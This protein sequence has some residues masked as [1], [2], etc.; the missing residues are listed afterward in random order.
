M[1]T[2]PIIRKEVLMALRTRKAVLMQAL[3]LLTVAALVF[4]LWPADG[5]QDIGGHQSRRILAVLAV[6]QAVLVALFAPVFTASSLTIE[7]ERNT[8]ESLFATA[9]KPWE[10]VLG[11]MVGSLSFLVLLVLSGVPAL[12][13]PLLLGGLSGG[14]VLAAV[15][16]LIVTA[17]YLGTVGLL[18]SSYMHRSYRSI[19]VTFAVLVA[20]CFVAAVPAWPVSRNL[21]LLGGPAWQAAVHVIASI[22][23]LQ[24]VLSLVL[25]ESPYTPAVAGMPA[26]WQTYFVVSLTLTAVAGLLCYRRL[27]RPIAPPRPRETMRVVERGEF[28]G[29]TVFY[30][31]FFD[32]NR[33]KK[34][35]GSLANP[36]L[37]KEFRTRPLLQTR[38][39]MRAIGT[40]LVASILLVFL[41]AISV[42]AF[43]TEPSSFYASLSSAVAAMM[44]VLVVL[45]GP[46]MTAGA[47]CSDR[48]S[49]V[50]ELLRATPLSSWTIVSGK[51]Q[52]CVI[53]L[54]LVVMSMLPALAVLL[55]FEANLW[56]YV[57]AAAGVVGVTVLLV[58]TAGMFFSSL[59][60]RTATS[61]AWTYAL[62]VAIGLLSLLALLGQDLF[63]PRLIQAV[64]SVN[65]IAAAMA[66]AGSATMVTYDIV[67]PYLMISG[68]AIATMFTATVWRVHRLRRTDD[69]S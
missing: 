22:S 18:V 33:R 69:R 67:Q 51:F 31:Y 52:A 46:A 5:L 49:G 21:I 39:L 40:C 48:E 55:Y 56:P 30:L 8:L 38:W 64:F 23:P 20:L 29:R 11:K 19:I 3:Y 9:L 50:W 15:G 4:L 34:P 13:S 47:I 60:A 68:I 37:M 57:T 7:R 28:S 61:T 59:F 42:Q 24:A 62:L 14:E 16:L 43:M 27:C 36:I 25:G 26:Y 35:I 54:L 53:P 32:P 6:A 41:V 1:V 58:A 45:V 10:I 44:A 2:N 65:P 12:A 66:A 63:P 17:V